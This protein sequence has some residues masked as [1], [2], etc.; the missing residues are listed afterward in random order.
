MWLPH[1]FV[2]RC[3][4]MNEVWVPSDFSR[5]HSRLECTAHMSFVATQIFIASGVAPSKLV[6][7][8]EGVNTTHFDP[9]NFEPMP[10]PQASLEHAPSICWVGKQSKCLK[11]R[12]AV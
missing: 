2:S 11:G 1:E 8:P 5:Q 12:G 6:I 7:V 10:L 3:N 4:A 9:A